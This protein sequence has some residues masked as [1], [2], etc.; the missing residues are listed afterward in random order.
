M[1]I[2]LS[3]FFAVIALVL[4]VLAG[5]LSAGAFTGDVHAQT[6]AYFGLASLTTSFLV[7]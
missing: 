1:K 5:L 4:F 3:F 7:P 2:T 6:L